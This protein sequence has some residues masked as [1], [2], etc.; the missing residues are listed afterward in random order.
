MFE[1]PPFARGPAR[2]HRWLNLIPPNGGFAP[3]IALPDP[4]GT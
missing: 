2:A 4:V 3:A 1:D